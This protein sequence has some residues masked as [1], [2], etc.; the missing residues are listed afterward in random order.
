MGVDPEEILC[1]LASGLQQ[2]WSG[3][4]TA[5]LYQGEVG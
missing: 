5:V 1:C 3:E 2:E 4:R